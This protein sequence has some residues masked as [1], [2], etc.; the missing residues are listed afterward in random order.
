MQVSSPQKLPYERETKEIHVSPSTPSEK[1]QP[2]ASPQ[3]VTPKPSRPL[4]IS[5]AFGEEPKEDHRP[6]NIVNLK[7]K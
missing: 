4:I 7:D 1:P 3:P 2:K 6:G 5:P